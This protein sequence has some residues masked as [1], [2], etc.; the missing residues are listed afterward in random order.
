[1]LTLLNF[2]KGLLLFRFLTQKIEGNHLKYIVNLNMFIPFC[3]YYVLTNF[4]NVKSGEVLLNLDLVPHGPV[5]PAP[6]QQQQSLLSIQLVK[7][8]K[9]VKS[10]LIGKSDPYA[11]LK[12][13]QQTAK[14]H[15]INKSQVKL[16]LFWGFFLQIIYNFPNIK[17]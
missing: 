5:K 4:Q 12:Y 14:T 9:L 17:C 6:L 3:I 13:G 15:T 11:V 2:W 1:M 16:N 8:N 10:D 7:A